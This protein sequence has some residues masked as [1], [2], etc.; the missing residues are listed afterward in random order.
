MK[1][2]RVLVLV[3]VSTAAARAWAQES[4]PSPDAG[5]EPAPATN[6]GDPVDG[7]EP[8]PPAQGADPELR[9]AFSPY[10]W[11]TGFSGNVSLRGIETDVSKS[12]FQILDNTDSVFGLMGALDV[13]YGRFVFQLNGSWVTADLSRER[14]DFLNGSVAAEVELDASWTEVFAGYRLYDTPLRGEREVDGRVCID[15]FAGVRYTTLDVDTTLR[16]S[17]TL[18]LPGGQVINPGAAIGRDRSED[19]FEPFTG[20]RAVFNFDEH[21]VIQLRGDIGGFGVDDSS[22]AWQGIAVFGY[23]W[24]FDGWNAGVFGGYRALGQ[25]YASGDF[26]WDVVT[27]GPILGGSVWFHF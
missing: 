3:L 11:L 24:R 10:A 15:A 21:W 23:Q 20:V 27:H 5:P 25:D 13:D 22:F 26:E 1:A 6:P 2:Y 17:S 7:H 16:A 19:W 9:L 14:G 18:T 12:F 8:A 4:T